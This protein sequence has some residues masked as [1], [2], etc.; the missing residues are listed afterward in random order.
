MANFARMNPNGEKLNVFLFLPQNRWQVGNLDFFKTQVTGVTP[1]AQQEPQLRNSRVIYPPEQ[2]SV[3]ESESGNLPTG[4]ETKRI[5]AV[6]RA[7]FE[8][9]LSCILFPPET[10]PREVFYTKKSSL[11]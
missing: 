2:I 1:A 3:L 11:M 10:G 5:G 6:F 8:S 4:E 9:S 7:E